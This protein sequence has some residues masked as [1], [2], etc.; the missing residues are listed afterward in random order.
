MNN[1]CNSIWAYCIQNEDSSKYNLLCSL[2][3]IFIIIII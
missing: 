2:I 3:F 1:I